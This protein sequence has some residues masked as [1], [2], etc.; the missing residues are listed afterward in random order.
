MDAGV[1]HAALI[2]TGLLTGRSKQKKF[3]CWKLSKMTETELVCQAHG[4]GSDPRFH[5]WGLR[6][7]HS[8]IC[9]SYLFSVPTVSEMMVH[10]TMIIQIREKREN[11]TFIL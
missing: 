5:W 7:W 9:V 2:S 8:D 6:F 4:R 1:F 3:L 10:R 11:T